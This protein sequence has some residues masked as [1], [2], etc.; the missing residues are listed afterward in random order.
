MRGFPQTGVGSRRRKG[1][2]WP[3]LV[4]VALLVLGAWSFAGRLF[5]GQL[6]AKTKSVSGGFADISVSEQD[7]AYPP[8]DT[9]LFRTRPRRVYVYVV[10]RDL[11][12]SGRGGVEASV[13]RKTSGPLLSRLSSTGLRVRGQPSRQLYAAGRGVSGVLRFVVSS[14]SGKLP[15]GLYEVRVRS[16]GGG[17]AWKSFL[18]R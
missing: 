1:R 11:S 13:T 4:L 7:R 15:E 12:V 8:P 9:D 17:E 14:N 5:E 18:V 16:A 3:A 10:V 2:R 6:P